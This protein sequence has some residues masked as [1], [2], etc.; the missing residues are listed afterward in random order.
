[1]HIENVYKMKIFCNNRAQSLKC[2]LN[3]MQLNIGTYMYGKYILL[4][5]FN[6]QYG[7]GYITM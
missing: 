3:D 7:T 1:M 5:K 2:I 4:N 6:S